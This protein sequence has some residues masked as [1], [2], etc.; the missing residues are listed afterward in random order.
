M[1]LERTSRPGVTDFPDKADSLAPEVL[2]AEVRLS[3]LA[4]ARV[5]D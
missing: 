1:A 2:T 3:Q 5:G 4:G